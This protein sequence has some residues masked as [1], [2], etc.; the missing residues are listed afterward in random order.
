MSSDPLIA[1]LAGLRSNVD[2]NLPAP[3]ANDFNA[4]NDVAPHF[5]QSLDQDEG[6]ICDS[7][8]HTS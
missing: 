7:P 6:N 2:D 1:A 4:E 3:F 5:N 8:S